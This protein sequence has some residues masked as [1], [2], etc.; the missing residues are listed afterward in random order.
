MC[1]NSFRCQ[2]NFTSK[3]LTAYRFR[4]RIWYINFIK[5]NYLNP[6][7]L[8]FWILPLDTNIFWELYLST[9]VTHT[10]LEILQST[11]VLMPS[12]LYCKEQH[13]DILKMSCS[14]VLVCSCSTAS[15]YVG[16]KVACA[17]V[18]NKISS[19]DGGLSKVT[20]KPFSLQ[21]CHNFWFG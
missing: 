5:T 9:K 16:F 21:W 18:R 4:G 1:R 15:G 20:E 3:N 12:C 17:D 7:K 19:L 14:S 8:L 13:F 6:V 11:Y 2:G 10:Y